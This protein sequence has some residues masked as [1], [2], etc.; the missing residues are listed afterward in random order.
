MTFGL[1]PASSQT[2]VQTSAP[3]TNNWRAVA[4]SADGSKLVAVVA[5]G[6]IYTS[7]NSGFNWMQTTAPSNIWISVASSADGTGLV[8]VGNNSIYTSANGGATW[9]SEN[10]PEGAPFEGW[11]SVAS[12]AD[13]TKL[14]AGSQGYFSGGKY[15][16]GMISTSSNSGGSWDYSLSIAGEGY[17]NNWWCVASSADGSKLVAGCQPV[18]GSGVIY[19]WLNTLGFWR[20]ASAP[21][22]EYWQSVASSADGTKMFAGE[23]NGAIY[24]STNS[25]TTWQLTSAPGEYASPGNGMYWISIA[26]SADG[27]KLV[28]AANGDR[29]YTS[30]DSGQTW[31]TNNV[32]DTNWTSVASSADGNE[33]VAAVGQGGI[34]VSQNA[35]SPELN[36]TL[37]N[38]SFK[39]SW[40]IP[41]T[42]FVMQQSSDLSSWS[43]ESQ[44]AVTLKKLTK[45]HQALVAVASEV[46]LCILGDGLSWV[47]P[48]PQ[49]DPVENLDKG[50]IGKDAL[51]EARELWEKHTA[52]IEQWSS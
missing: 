25:G 46:S 49:F 6:G 27:S 37:T 10:A 42:N 39:L 38:G 33:L 16:G 8:A 13:G 15:I 28:A 4:S 22:P 48:Q 18:G 17:P 41:S 3:V 50:W 21:N 12:S 11:R 5:G 47:V 14:I 29:I 7:T 2:W 20:Q 44:K 19:I 32:P 43:T 24:M 45:C 40:L 36:L 34:Y 23:A 1:S 26:S 52:A 31:I 51:E 35:P 30:S 9:Q